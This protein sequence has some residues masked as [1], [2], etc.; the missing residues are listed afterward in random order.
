MKGTFTI[1]RYSQIRFQILKLPFN[2]H[3]LVDLIILLVKALVYQI[4]KVLFVKGSKMI[5]ITNLNKTYDD[6]VIINITFMLI[7]VRLLV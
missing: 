6:K 2:A 7:K 3:A 4:S 5:N 1:T